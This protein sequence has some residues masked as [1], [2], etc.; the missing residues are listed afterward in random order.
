MYRMKSYF[1]LTIYVTIVTPRPSMNPKV[2]AECVAPS[3]EHIQQ[4]R[5]LYNEANIEQQV[6]QHQR[7]NKYQNLRQY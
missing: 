3:N 6:G 4:T 5:G 2:R 1:S 7:N